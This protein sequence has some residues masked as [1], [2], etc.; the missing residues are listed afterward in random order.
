[1]LDFEWHVLEDDQ[2]EPVVEHTTLAKRRWWRSVLIVIVLLGLLGLAAAIAV[3]RRAQE[4]IAEAKKDV[5]AS[6]SL[7]RRAAAEADR[8]LLDAVLGGAPRWKSQQHKLLEQGL[9]FDREPFGLAAQAPSPD[10]TE[11]SLTPGL[12]DAIVASQ[13]AYS[14]AGGYGIPETVRLRHTFFYRFDGQR[15]LH[16][17]PDDGFWGGTLNEAG[18]IVTLI[19]PERDKDIGAR[20]AADLDATFGELCTGLQE[21]L[22]PGSTRLRITLSQEPASL[23]GMLPS[24]RQSPVVRERALG[25]T[26]PSPTLFGAP[27]DEASY[28][29]LYRIYAERIARWYAET[30]SGFR[31][32]GYQERFYRAVFEKA[33][34]QQGLRAWPLVPRD[35]VRDAAPAPAPD[36]DIAVYCVESTR[37]GGILYRYEPAS[38]AWS[39]LLAG[40]AAGSMGAL[41]NGDGVV[42]Q[43]IPDGADHPDSR[44][45]LWQD[46]ETRVLLDAPTVSTPVFF[47]GQ[48]DPSGRWL[49][50]GLTIDINRP[51][52]ALL[53]LDNCAA[54]GCR[55]DA[56]PGLPTWSPDGRRTLV[57]AGGFSDLS[58]GDGVARSL[59][60]VGSGFG[61]F[62]VDNETYGYA[63]LTR[64]EPPVI[65]TATVEGGQTNRLLGAQDLLEP[66]PDAGAPFGMIHG[67]TNSVEGAAWLW[68]IAMQGRGAN[69]QYRLFLIDP[70]SG[71]T[72]QAP[73]EGSFTTP[74]FS[75]DGRWL[76][77]T[78]PYA[79]TQFI[80]LYDT[81][82]RRTN[83]MSFDAPHPAFSPPHLAWS[84]D[85]RWLLVLHDGVLHLIAPDQGS[86]TAI[87]PES[88][89]CAFAAWINRR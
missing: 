3:D 41:P 44:L 22:C 50:V 62:W 39:T 79:A 75:P 19:Y 64:F 43:E 21:P 7:V 29:A 63:A 49:V 1:M 35:I 32:D 9:I 2:D 51:N 84:R 78:R 34:A 74:T 30:L 73:F 52:Y 85:S 53:D 88:P 83:T 23:A 89:G 61:P 40:P 86:H 36:Q 54:S 24:E 8:E 47:T 58:M 56:L 81:E 48:A 25:F 87:V 67:A 68:T 17:P 4:T 60:R 13:Q 20:L 15:W 38:G 10:A 26:L 82:T 28:G 69:E 18:K 70:R 5:L 72:I 57:T 65:V 66:R 16:F 76:A 11:V 42:L 77:V 31:K 27:V 12:K 37:R 80:H 59:A 71:R 45:L 33:L 14:T 46:G 6:H 55:W